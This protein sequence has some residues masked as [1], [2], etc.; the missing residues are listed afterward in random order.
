MSNRRSISGDGAR[1][2]G[3]ATEPDFG[4]HRDVAYLY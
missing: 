4:L 2:G 3:D 1:F